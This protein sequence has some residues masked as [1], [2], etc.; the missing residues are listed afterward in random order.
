VAITDKDSAETVAVV[1]G[2]THPQAMA[3]ADLSRL[4]RGSKSFHLISSRVEALPAGPSVRAQY[5]T[6]SPKDPVT[7]KRVP[8]LVDRYY[9]SGHGK[10]AVLTL[11]TPRGVDNVD[12]FRLIA[13]SF[14]WH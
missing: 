14:R 4:T 9:I 1:T 2:N 3:R 7:G 10:E 6:L 8:V 13:H 11:Q 12:A 5:R